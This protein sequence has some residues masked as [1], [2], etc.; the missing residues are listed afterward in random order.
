MLDGSGHAVDR[1]RLA[2]LAGRLIDMG[3]AVAAIKLGDQGLYLR[4][5]SDAGRVAAFCDRL[6]S[7]RGR[8]ARSRDPVALLS[9]PARS[10]GRRD[11]ATARSPASSRRC[12][13]ARGLRARPPPRRPSAPAASRSRTARTA[14]WPGPR[15]RRGW[16]AGGR[17]CRLRS[18]SAPPPAASGTLRAHSPSPHREVARRKAR[19]H[20]RRPGLRPGLHPGRREGRRHGLRPGGA[21]HGSGHRRAPLARRLPRPDPRDRP[22]GTRRHH[23]HE[24]QHERDPHRRGA[25]VRRLAGH[26]GGARQRHDRHPP[27]RGGGLPRAAVAA[28]SHGDDRA[29]HGR[30]GRRPRPLLDHPGQRRRARRPRARGLP[31]LPPGGRSGR[32]SATSSRSSTRTF[33][34]RIRP[35][36]AGRF[37]NDVIVRTLAGVPR[38]GRPLFLKIPYHGPRAMEELA[39]YDP[40][41]VLGI[42]GG[43][44][45]TTYDAFF[46]LEEARRHGARAAL[47]GRKINSSEHPLTFVRSAARDRRRRDRTPRRPAGPTTASWTGSGSSRTGRCSEDMQ[48]TQG[49]T[50]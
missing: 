48:A 44:A 14:S 26:A 13:G 32:A 25:P 10:P 19:E 47:F 33:P 3:V 34:A 1:S 5:T 28:V 39:A 27:P 8:V 37:L 41:L 35:R 49:R 36:I 16:S 50:A 40:H 12:C 4:T 29:D 2:D 11:R 15:S 18:S 9:S 31:G 45:G 43:S 7:R 30:R 21:G 22:P 46:L 6:G 38:A 20:P 23:A 17:G 24:R 42:L